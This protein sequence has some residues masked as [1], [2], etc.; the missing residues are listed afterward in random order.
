MQITSIDLIAKELEDVKA[1]F[2]QELQFDEPFIAGMFEQ[3]NECQGKMLRP[4][5]VLLSGKACGPIVRNHLVIATVMEMIHIATLVHDDVLDEAQRRRYHGT[6]NSLHGNEAA[7]LLG[8]LLVSCAFRLCNSIDN[9]LFSR[10]ISQTTYTVCRGE[11]MQLHHRGNYQLNEKE[12]LDIISN[13]T[14]SLM[15]ICCYLG[16]LIAGAQEKLCR[17]LE[18]FGQNMGIA[19]Q[20]MDDVTDLCGDENTSGKT[21]RTDM[22]KEKMTLSIIH[23]LEQGSI[24]QEKQLQQLLCEYDKE[25]HIILVEKLR[26]TGSIDYACKRAADYLGQAKE[27]L[28]AIE[29]TDIRDALCDMVDQFATSPSQEN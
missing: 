23:F 29:Q 28:M 1:L 8:D 12:Y 21:L 7:V 22:V 26:L 5:L 19:Y 14:A 2:R 16:A 6:I 27:N 18:A 3:V 4:A 11:L 15:A 24:E 9:Q 17:S 25:K 20:I 10:L 13:K